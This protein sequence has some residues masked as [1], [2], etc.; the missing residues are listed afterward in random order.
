M[1]NKLNAEKEGKHLVQLHNA[2]KM[3]PEGFFS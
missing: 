2:D 3:K 1:R